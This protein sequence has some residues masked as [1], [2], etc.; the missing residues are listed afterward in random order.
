MFGI[1][2]QIPVSMNYKFNRFFSTLPY[3]IGNSFYFLKRTSFLSCIV[4]VFLLF[5][6]ANRKGWECLNWDKKDQNFFEFHRNVFFLGL[7]SLFTD[8]SSEMICPLL[9]VFLISVRGAGT[10]FAGLVEGGDKGEKGE[11]RVER[12]EVKA[13]GPEESFFATPNSQLT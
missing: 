2:Y 8:L 4:S 5:S 11:L 12:W 9:P 13:E 6:V 1:I 10:T 3:F 7:V